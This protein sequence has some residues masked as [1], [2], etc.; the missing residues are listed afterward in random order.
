MFSYVILEFLDAEG[1]GT[2]EKV[3][4]VNT[5]LHYGST[6]T[7]ATNFHL[8]REY[9]AR[10]LRAWLDDQAEQYPNQ[11]VMGDM[12]AHITGRGATTLSEYTK[13]DGLLQARNEALL[14]SDTG[15]T[16]TSSTSYTDRTYVFDHILFRNM[17]AIEYSVIDNTVDNGKYP[18]DHLPVISTFICYAE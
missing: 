16:L 2:G 17:K 3:L 5:H 13:N 11:I 10:I 18:S 15:G 7:N 14:K 4:V 6:K 12:N 8:L 9:E 1:N